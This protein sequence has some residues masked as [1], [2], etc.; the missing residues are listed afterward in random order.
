MTK[1]TKHSYSFYLADGTVDLI[2]V[3]ADKLF[4]KGND[5]SA[6]Q[7]VDTALRLC[8][9]L[10]DVLDSIDKQPDKYVGRVSP[11]DT[12]TVR[13]IALTGKNK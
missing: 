11:A 10:L 8:V 13:L 2:P 1:T 3:L 9:S 6:S 5:V 4:D 12:Y 7:T